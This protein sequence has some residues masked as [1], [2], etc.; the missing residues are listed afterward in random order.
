MKIAILTSH[1]PPRWGGISRYTYEIASHW[2]QHGADILVAS[3]VPPGEASDRLSAEFDGQYTYLPYSKGGYWHAL[4]VIREFVRW[5][6]EEGADLV[7]FP[8]W[9]PF[10]LFA[11]FFPSILR[12]YIVG[13]HG[14]EVL[15][16]LNPE[17]N[18]HGII[19]WLGCHLLRNAKA[20]FVV[21]NYTAKQL[22]ELHIASDRIH[23]FPNGVD[24]TVFRPQSVSKEDLFRKYSVQN[25]T[26]PVL[27]TV[28]QLNPRKGIDIT[29]EAVARLHQ[30]GRE[31]SYVIIG[32]GNDEQRLREII[33]E[34]DLQETTYIF[35][36]VDDESL[37]K[38][39]NVADIFVMLSRKEG[40]ENVEGFGISLL[41]ANACG[42]PVI[43]GRSGGVPDVVVD[44]ETGYLLDPTDTGMLESTIHYLLDHPEKAEQLGRQGRKRVVD[45]YNWHH[46]TRN[47]LSLL[48]NIKTEL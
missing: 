15:K 41:E 12:R 32:R 18:I 9:Y 10:A 47:M 24:H 8:Y 1:F 3:T 48:E 34:R 31:L 21:S 36:D 13:T 14:A 38:F 46:I 11:P 37:L 25:P 2:K 20:V 19:H 4:L 43:G 27:L 45:Q 40:A 22:E 26:A 33:V 29:L 16:L 39:Y 17:R 23:V 28:A 35:T 30:E 6:K 7:F 44:G 42:L 5:T